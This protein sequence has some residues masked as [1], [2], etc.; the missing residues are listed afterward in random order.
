MGLPKARPQSRGLRTT[1]T[2][3]QDKRQLLVGVTGAAN[4][5]PWD[6]GGRQPLDDPLKE[7]RYRLV[8]AL[9]FG[10]TPR[11][12]HLSRLPISE[13]RHYPALAENFHERVMPKCRAD[14]E[15]AAKRAMA[16]VLGPNTGEVPAVTSALLGAVWG[17]LHLVVLFGKL[18]APKPG[19]IDA[20][21][22]CALGIC[23]FLPGKDPA[24]E[25]AR[26]EPSRR[27]PD[28]PE[29]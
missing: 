20:Q 27:R 12:I 18:D 19:R 11:L 29:G 8:A 9:A 24:V 28:D 17:E 16:A 1:L 23:G 5:F 6:D 14:I 15:A 22:D 13:V 21:V 26:P 7:L 3:Y 10:L 4:D 25:V 2:L